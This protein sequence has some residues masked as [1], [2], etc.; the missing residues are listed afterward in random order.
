MAIDG[1]EDDEININNI[2]DYEVESSDE[3][4]FESC[5]QQEESD[6]TPATESETST[7]NESEIED[8]SEVSNS[9]DLCSDEFGND[10]TVNRNFMTE[11]FI[12][13]RETFSMMPGPFK[14]PYIS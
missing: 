12:T 10:S 2:E 13:M 8:V 9:E 3:D 7:S 14:L 1:S 6:H 5:N 4:P 11:D